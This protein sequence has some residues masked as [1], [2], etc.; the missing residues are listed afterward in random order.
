MTGKFTGIF[1]D[2]DD[3]DEG[4]AFWKKPIITK[5]GDKIMPLVDLIKTRVT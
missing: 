2:K 5:G 1:N 3:D 4:T